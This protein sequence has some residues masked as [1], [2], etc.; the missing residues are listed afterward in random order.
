MTFV[1]L[2]LYLCYY[3]INEKKR[4]NTMLIGII[5]ALII[6]I[7]VYAVVFIPSV[8]MKIGKIGDINGHKI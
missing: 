1:A 8:K 5:V 4:V 3:D 6:Y 7:A 2:T